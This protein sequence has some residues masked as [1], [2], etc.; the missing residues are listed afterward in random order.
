MRSPF[1]FWLMSKRLLMIRY[2]FTNRVVRCSGSSRSRVCF[3]N[4]MDVIMIA[5]MSQNCCGM[6]YPKFHCNL[7]KKFSNR[8]KIDT[9]VDT[10]SAEAFVHRKN[11]VNDCEIAEWDWLESNLY[12]I[13]LQINQPRHYFEHEKSYSHGECIS[14]DSKNELKFDWILSKTSQTWW[15]VRGRVERK[16]NKARMT[17]FISWWDELWWI[18]RDFKYWRKSDSYLLFVHFLLYWMYAIK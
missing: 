5:R 13:S 18:I 17:N 4:N 12:S 11:N 14:L 15:T 8:T 1:E 10:I 7:S 3:R 16:L 2:C 9:C 6:T